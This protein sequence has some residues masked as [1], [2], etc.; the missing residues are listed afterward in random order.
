MLHNKLLSP[1]LA[2]VF[3]EFLTYVAATTSDTNVRNYET[4][5]K[6][7]I[8]E[9]GGRK[10]GFLSAKHADQWRLGF[11]E[12]G[13]SRSTI[14]GYTQALKYLD[15]FIQ[16]RYPGA[17]SPFADHIRNKPPKPR[18]GKKLPDPDAVLMLQETAVFIVDDPTSRQ[19]LRDAVIVL[20]MIE[21]GCRRSEVAALEVDLMGLD[22]PFVEVIDGRELLV[23]EA[24]LPH[25]KTDEDHE[26]MQTVDYTEPMAAALRKW[27]R[28]RPKADR[29]G[30]KHPQLFV[31][32]GSCGRHR[33]A[34]PK[35]CQICKSYGQ[36]VTITTVRFAVRNLVE[37]AGV[38]HI[39]PHQLRHSFGQR[40]LD[41]S[42]AEIA[43]QRLR[44]KDI[45]TT[46]SFYGHQDKT[47]RRRGAVAASL[48]GQKVGDRR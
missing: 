5:L 48:L 24:A 12:R 14:Y 22:D 44:H 18:V 46:V 19:A 45:R 11:K 10:I 8:E 28:V 31:G 33:G 3:D 23:Y 16:E 47:R 9:H 38:D 17:C 6:S 21:T 29:D 36:P 43:R 27:L 41:T 30:R 40:A 20:W 15:S 7:F 32:V 2:D 34:I 25:S 4:R 13:L 1:R 37:A 35:T 42:N 26:E 39:S